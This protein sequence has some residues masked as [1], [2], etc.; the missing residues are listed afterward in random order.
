[1]AASPPIQAQLRVSGAPADFAVPAAPTTE[2]EAAAMALTVYCDFERT[3]PA[4]RGA[5]RSAA[6]M[7]RLFY[8][9]TPATMFGP[10]SPMVFTIEGGVFRA[11][12]DT[13][14]AAVGPDATPQVASAEPCEYVRL[15]LTTPSAQLA[16]WHVTGVQDI[17]TG[18]PVT[19][20]RLVECLGGTMDKQPSHET[21]RMLNK[22]M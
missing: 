19:V 8:T 11:W 17:Q 18:M 15:D 13:A 9:A 2:A 10:P 22:L 3:R 1:M 16:Q 20:K 21:V 5:C 7:Q 12:Q 6:D 4:S 14:A